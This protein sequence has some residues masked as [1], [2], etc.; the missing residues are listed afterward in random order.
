MSIVFFRVPMLRSVRAGRVVHASTNFIFSLSI[1]IT[2]RQEPI[3]LDLHHISYSIIELYGLYIKFQRQV[4]LWC[5]LF[6]FSAWNEKR[7]TSLLKYAFSGCGAPEEMNLGTGKKSSCWLKVPLSGRQLS[8][9]KG[10]FRHIGV[11]KLCN[12]SA[13]KQT[14]ADY[15]IVP[16]ADI[17]I[18][19]SGHKIKV[20]SN[21]SLRHLYDPD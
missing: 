11:I 6:C 12:F 2:Y 14:L 19:Q 1:I 8:K 20:A 9:V 10:S 16:R 4:P 21:K 5:A 7:L 17:L 15:R 18:P 3:I 13:L